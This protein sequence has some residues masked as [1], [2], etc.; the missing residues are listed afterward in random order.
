MKKIIVFLGISLIL[1][2]CNIS[3]SN[4]NYEFNTKTIRWSMSKDFEIKDIV[5]DMHYILLEET[6]ESIFSDI[7][8]IIIKN[9]RIYILNNRPKDVLVFDIKGK[10]LHKVGS[11]GGGPGEYLPNGIMNFTVDEN[12]E[13]FIND[14]PKGEMMKYDKNGKYVNSYKKSFSFSD[15][16]LLPDNQFMLS[17]DIYNK[18]NLNRKVILTD[19]LKSIKKSYFHFDK[20]YKHNK[21]NMTVFQPFEDKIAYMRPINDTL[22]IF[23]Y[24]GNLEQA[25]FFDFGNRKLPE[26]LK[27]DHEKV[28]EDR[29]MGSNSIYIYNTPICIKNYIFSEIVI[30]SQ[31]G[32]SVY[33]TTKNELTHEIIA[34]ENFSL[35]NINTP[36]CAL[37]DNLLVSYLDAETYYYVKDNFSINPEVD[38]HLENGGTIIILNTIR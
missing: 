5:E 6:A 33:D 23:D 20:N 19:D 26:E 15:Y 31:R 17:L 38:A 37:S 14:Y 25:W 28:I 16:L 7:Y 2:G 32:I 1:S 27:N 24:K 21:L 13:V 10:F 34:P 3:D 18:K 11:R 30:N 29:R 9:E 35:H 4:N 8:K 22:F 36:L 12:D